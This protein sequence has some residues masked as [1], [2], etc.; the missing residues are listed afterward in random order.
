MDNKQ[1]LD[2]IMAGHSKFTITSNVTGKHL[3]FTARRPHGKEGDSSSPVFISVLRGPDN[4]HDFSYIGTIFPNNKFV[5]T[6]NSRSHPVAFQGFAWFF[7]GL[8]D[9]GNVLSRATFQHS[10]ECGRCGRELTDPVSIE[11]G[12]GPV[13]RERMG[14]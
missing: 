9:E 2:F 5:K 3:T 11:V 10:G 14:V 12:L 6:K 13:C 4:T 1:I 8:C 7:N